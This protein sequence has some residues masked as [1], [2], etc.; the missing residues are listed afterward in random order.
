MMMMMMMVVEIKSLQQM[1]FSFWMQAGWW[2]TRTT[3]APPSTSPVAASSR[4]QCSSSW[5]TAWF[6]GAKLWEKKST[7]PRS[8]KRLKFN[9]RRFGLT[10]LLPTWCSLGGLDLVLQLGSFLL[11][12]SQVHKCCFLD[13][14]SFFYKNLNVKV[15][16]LKNLKQTYNS[17]SIADQHTWFFFRVAAIDMTWKSS[18]KCP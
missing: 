12:S 16:T 6:R 14:I 11:I 9:E 3:T 4:R 10:G 18:C 13:E 5:S 8:Q 1:Y 17:N 15:G 2:I 7:N